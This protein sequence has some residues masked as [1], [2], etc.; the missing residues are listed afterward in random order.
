M[1]DGDVSVDSN[2]RRRPDSGGVSEEGQRNDER[3]D[4]RVA[5]LLVDG[6]IEL[7]EVHHRVD[8]VQRE[9]R[10]QQ[11]VVHHR[12]ALCVQQQEHYLYSAILLC[13]THKVL[14]RGSHSFTC[15]L[16]NACLSFLSVHQMAPPLAEIADIQL[17]LTTHY[18]PRSD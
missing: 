16:H 3:D 17:Q 5:V 6:G 11:Q 2:E 7:E 1:A 12:N 15:K 9:R 4:K 10:Q 13:H 8:A 14:S 18:P